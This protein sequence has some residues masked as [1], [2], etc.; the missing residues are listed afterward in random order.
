MIHDLY[1]P[2][3]AIQWMPWCAQLESQSRQSLLVGSDAGRTDRNYL[4]WLDVLLPS[5]EEGEVSDG[6]ANQVGQQ[7]EIRVVQRV[8]HPG[9]VRRLAIAPEIPTLVATG[10]ITGNVLVFNLQRCPLKPVPDGQSRPDATLHGHSACCSSVAWSPHQHGLV[11]SC[12]IDGRLCLWDV[13]N[14]SAPA[15]GDFPV[16]AMRTI[17][18]AHGYFACQ[19]AVFHEDNKSTLASVGLDGRLRVWDTRVPNNVPTIDVVAHTGGALCLG[20]APG[21]PW[22]LATGGKD[23]HVRC[24]DLRHATAAFS[25]L[26]GHEGDVLSVDWK[27]SEPGILATSGA[28]GRAI[29]WDTRHAGRKSHDRAKPE[30]VFVHDVHGSDSGRPIPVNAVS[31]GHSPEENVLGSVDG[32]GELHI[33]QPA[34]I[35]EHHREYCSFGAPSCPLSGHPVPGQPRSSSCP[36]GDT[37]EPLRRKSRAEVGQHAAAGGRMVNRSPGRARGRKFLAHRRVW[38]PRQWATDWPMRQ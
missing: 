3:L 22:L 12:A 34:A 11:L 18:G 31:W 21:S 4:T 29:V 27:R 30:L 19:S 15:C 26:S 16:P 28:D 17:E 1:W 5:A 8:N 36:R 6:D 37:I 35:D 38:P 13:E 10:T 33:W 25:V 2:A 24:W 23:N 9:P 7:E 32:K 20:F 14:A